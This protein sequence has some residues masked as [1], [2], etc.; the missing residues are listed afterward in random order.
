MSCLPAEPH[1]SPPL[2]THTRTHCH[3]EA[4]Q[5][6]ISLADGLHGFAAPLVLASQIYT[7][8]QAQRL[9]AWQSCAVDPG[10]VSTGV[11]RHSV[12]A[13]G[14]MRWLLDSVYAPSRDGAQAIIHAATCPLSPSAPVRPRGMASST[15]QE[16]R[17]RQPVPP[18]QL[19]VILP[20]AWTVKR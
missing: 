16:P 4:M 18:D 17:S 13:K 10:G 1:P 19:K 15:R 6:I 5:P 2:C 8:F 12:F 3:R 14:P 20:A 11:W 9:T 7:A